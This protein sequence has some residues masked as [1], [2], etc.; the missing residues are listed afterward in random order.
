MMD[1]CNEIQ[2][3]INYT[4]SNLR[5]ISEMGIK[6]SCKRYKNKNFLDSYVVTIH[7]LQKGFME[8]YLYWY[9]YGEPYVPHDTMVERMIGSTSTSSNV[10]GVVDDNSNLYR[11][12]VIDAM[13]MNHDH[14]SQ[15]LIVNEELNAD[16]SRFFMF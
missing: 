11:N 8:K 1:Y 6:C 12:M 10:H 13:G 15:C 4:L 2:G 7:L 5:N 14:A 9:A 3:F 16:T